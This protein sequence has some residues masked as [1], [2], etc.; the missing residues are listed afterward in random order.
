MLN[1]ARILTDRG[2]VCT[3]K[4][5]KELRDE[6]LAVAVLRLIGWVALSCDQLCNQIAMGMS[7][8]WEVGGEG[9]GGGGES[10]LTPML[11][12]DLKLPNQFATAWHTVLLTLLAVPNFKAAMSRAYCDT[13]RA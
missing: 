9:E 8:R 7:G 10:A 3:I 5:R 1:R 11:R 2:L 13:Y 12:N 4:T 6:Q